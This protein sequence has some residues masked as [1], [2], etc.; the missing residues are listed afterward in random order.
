MIGAAILNALLL[1][2]DS[3]VV[4]L[5]ITRIT[6]TSKSIINNI[7]TNNNNIPFIN[8]LLMSDVSDHLPIIVLYKNH[9]NINNN[10]TKNKRTTLFNR[11]LNKINVNKIRNVLINYDWSSILDNDDIESSFIDFINTITKVYHDNCPLVK[12]T[13]KFKNSPWIDNKIK[14]MMHKKDILYKKCINDNS[15]INRYIY[16]NA[17]NKFTNYLR[18]AKQLYYSNLTLSINSP[19]NIWKTL[20][21]LLNKTDNNNNNRNYFSKNNI[22]DTDTANNFNKYFCNVGIN[23][24]THLK[25]NNSSDIYNYNITSSVFFTFINLTELTNIINNMKLTYSKDVYDINSVLIKNIADIIAFP[26]S[27]LY[28]K[29]AGYF[30]DSLK[31]AKVIPIYKK[32]IKD[33]IEN[34][35]PISILPILSKILEKLIKT[36]ISSFIE[37][38]NIINNRQFGFRNNMSAIDAVNALN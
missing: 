17:R 38:N 15:L 13:T 24:A 20:N 27:I 18:T 25:S 29:C 14:K 19:K 16:I 10:K 31:I 8:G 12:I 37:N 30:P 5:L 35:R 3:F 28:N 21:N 22:S 2:A 32:G 34:Y 23:L 9:V 11:S 36:R 6:Y 33:N 26:L 4:L 1:C 7:Y